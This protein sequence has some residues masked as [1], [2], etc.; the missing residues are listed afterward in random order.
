MRVTT[1][2]QHGATVLAHSAAATVSTGLRLLVLVTVD[3]L[4][5]TPLPNY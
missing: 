5:D 2:A 1:A 3:R 4:L